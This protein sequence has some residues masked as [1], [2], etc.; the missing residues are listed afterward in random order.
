MSPPALSARLVRSAFQASIDEE[1]FNWLVRLRVAGT[2]ASIETGHGAR[3]VDSSFSFTASAAV[4][5]PAD[6]WDPA[7][8]MGTMTG[9]ALTSIPIRDTFWVPVLEDDLRTVVLDMPWRD[10]ELLDVT[11]TEDRTCVGTRSGTVYTTTDGELAM[12]I[13]IA[14][15]MVSRV[16]LPPIDTSLCNF[17]AGMASHEGLCTGIPRVSWPSP[18]DS[19]CGTGG[20]T[21]TCATAECN[22]WR[23]VAGFAAHGVEITD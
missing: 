10:F 2:S 5:P 16:D 13:T 19:F 22:A 14:D 12:Y 21:T 4:P 1:R 17:I 8:G 7:I 9:E 3:N 20:C 6:R 23:V 11:F 15:A 18:P